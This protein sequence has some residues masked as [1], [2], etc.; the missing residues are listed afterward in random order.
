MKHLRTL[1]CMLAC[2][3]LMAAFSGCAAKPEKAARDH[4]LELV[5]TMAEL[6]RSEAY[7]ALTTGSPTITEQLIP[8]QEGDVSE[9]AA[10]YTIKLG[11]EYL[12]NMA[13]W[14]EISEIPDSIKEV[15]NQKLIGAFATQ[16]LA[17]AGAQELAASAVC[18]AGKTFVDKTLTESVIYLYV[19]QNCPPAAVT[20]IPG[21]GGAVS[22]SG[23]FL[24]Y[25][26]VDWFDETALSA[27][28]ADM[29][30]ELSKVS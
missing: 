29:G 7:L 6:A 15:A 24:L 17:H 28:F 16:I 23:L 12:S 5:E 11:E 18:A 27:F 26:E 4:G 2:G 1:A 3:Y 22:A 13:E 20:F 19:F 10:V 9:P 14:S 25:D 30:A 21:E 8:V